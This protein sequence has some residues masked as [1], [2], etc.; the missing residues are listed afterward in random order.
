M[1]SSFKRIGNRYTVQTNLSKP[2]KS[3]SELH[4]GYT[5]DNVTLFENGRSES[6]VWVGGCFLSL[7]SGPS[8]MRLD[9]LSKMFIKKLN[10]PP[11]KHYNLF[12][13]I[14]IAS[15]IPETALPEPTSLN[16]L[17]SRF[18]WDNVYLYKNKEIPQEFEF[19]YV[20]NRVFR[21]ILDATYKVTDTD[22]AS[23]ILK[24]LTLDFHISIELMAEILAKAL[25]IKGLSSAE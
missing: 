18:T 7:F 17:V 2:Q 14:C 13:K 9:I 11:C 3:D 19:E 15:V 10:P 20:R 25:V 8:N 1:Y 6:D 5:S 22:S 24:E 21:N 12:E 16:K 4:T 23:K